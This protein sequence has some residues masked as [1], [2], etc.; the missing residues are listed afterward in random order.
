MFRNFLNDERGNFA[1]IFGLSIVPIMGVLT[2]GIDYSEMSRQRQLMINSLDAAGVATARQIVGGGSDASIKKY[3]ADFFQ[4]NLSKAINPAD[5]NLVVTLPSG[6]QGGG[7]LKMCSDLTYHPYFL[8]AFYAVL[9]KTPGEIKFTACTQV[10]LQNRLEVALVLDNSGSMN[11]VGAGATQSRLKLLKD[12]SKALINGFAARAGSV[13]QLSEPVRFS[14]V[15]FAASVNVGPANETASW[16]DVNGLSPIHHENF[17]W[18]SFSVVSNRSVVKNASTGIY[19]K[20]GNGWPA[21]ERN[22]KV[23]RFTLYREMKYFLNGVNGQKGNFSSW[24]G[25]VEA[26]PYPYNIDDTPP[27]PSNPATLFVPMFAPDESDVTSWGRTAANNW[28]ADVTRN[29]SSVRRQSYMPKYF[30]IPTYGS[31]A[32]LPEQSWTGPNYSCTTTPITPLVDITNTTERNQLL[33]AIDS[34]VANGATNVPEGLAWGWRTLSSAPPFDTGRPETEKGNTKAVIVMTDGANTY[35]TPE[36]LGRLDAAGNKSIYSAL[37]Y[38]RLVLN[39]TATGRIFQGA[40]ASTNTSL[41]DNANYTTAM[42]DLFETTRSTKTLCK[43]IKNSNTVVFTI[44]LDLDPRDR[45]EKAQIDTLKECAS[46]SSQTKG[47]KLYWEGSSKD[48]MKI[49]DEIA[50]E[51]SNLRIVS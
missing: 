17:D 27:T 51:L 23:T 9:N 46:E 39:P 44:S 18:S 45:Q 24:K 30:D 26:R 6:N 20:I 19:E 4:A 22:T 7:T 14:L 49:V 25:C 28:W 42:N 12:A 13:S 34:M 36:S 38:P 48:L 21:A 3:A 2:L 50:N 1:I 31:V 32:R 8:P 16:M 29:S 5:T 15:P 47:K 33:T 43:N 41:F 10:Q 35:Y 11:Q 37:G 40:L